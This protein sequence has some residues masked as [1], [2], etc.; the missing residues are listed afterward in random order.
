MKVYLDTCVY[1]RPFDNQSQPRVWLETLAFT[2][3]LQLVE[4]GKITL[5][6]SSVLAYEN[7]RNPFPPLTLCT[8]PARKQLR[9]TTS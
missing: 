6:N 4:L 5:V 9:L 1:N 7:S 8:W 2:V 3:I